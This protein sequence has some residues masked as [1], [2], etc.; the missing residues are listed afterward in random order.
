ML[1]SYFHIKGISSKSKKVQK[2]V[3]NPQ[4]KI[5][6]YINNDI[7]NN[8]IINILAQDKRIKALVFHTDYVK[9][10][11]TEL[12]KKKKNKRDDNLASFT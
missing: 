2:S 6:M 11:H 7:I 4:T 9:K 8:H 12:V 10:C 5:K 1:W 3:L